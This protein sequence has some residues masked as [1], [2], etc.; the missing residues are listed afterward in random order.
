MKV[1]L[2]KDTRITL[3]CNSRNYTIIGGENFYQEDVIE[4]YPKYF[5]GEESEK[6]VEKTEEQSE[7]GIISKMSKKQLDEYAEKEFNIK[8][9]RRKTL[10]KMKEEFLS[11]LEKS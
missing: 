4:M 8:L 1:N 6:E 3:S 2:P 10:K 9:D 7:E 5:I 11:M